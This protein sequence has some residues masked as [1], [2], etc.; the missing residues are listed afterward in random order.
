MSSD[1]YPF[2]VALSRLGNGDTREAQNI[3]AIRWLLGQ[4]P[5]PIILVT[6]RRDFSGD[7]L[8]ALGAR[9]DVTHLTWR[10]F[11]PA[12]LTGRRVMHAWPDREHLN[13]LWGARAAALVVIEWNEEHSTEWLKDA[14]PD[15]LLPGATHRTSAAAPAAGP[16]LPEDVASILTSTARWAAGYSGGL[17]W[18]EEDKL[19][20]DMMNRPE[21]WAAVTVE[22]VRAKCRELGMRPNDV[23]TITGFLQ[24]RKEGRR[25]NVRSTYKDFHF[26][27]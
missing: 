9:A 23:D 11:S 17:K 16:N 25:F 5:S 2:P 27:A 13:E 21:R 18:N 24:R 8:R 12:S 4:D 1:A 22:Q 19:K 26:G 14:A 3:R 15:L 10:S 6:P 20:A 7:S